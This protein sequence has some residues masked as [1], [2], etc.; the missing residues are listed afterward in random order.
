MKYSK[1]LD[2]LLGQKSKLKILRHLSNTK[3]EMSGRQIA[4]EIGMS[5]WVCHQALKELS[6]QGVVLMRNVGN[7]HLFR[8]NE[9]NYLV[10]EVLMPLFEAEEGL[11]DAAI[12]EIVQGLE[13][14]ITSIV[15]YGSIS[16][17]EEEPTSDFDL[18]VVVPTSNDTKSA[19]DFFAI[20]ND[21]FI[22][23]FGNVL[24][25]LILA[26]REF[27]ERY[28]GGD[29]LIREIANTGRVVYGKSISEVI[30]YAPQEDQN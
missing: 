26:A 10:A 29:Q 21:Y 28:R 1:A 6:A 12:S 23:R 17:G 22:S 2:D 16:R 15:L 9:R 30:T 5:P 3:M 20:K 13:D 14:R 27:Q 18:L 24:S 4:S 19:E 11:L 7:T 8:I 25:P